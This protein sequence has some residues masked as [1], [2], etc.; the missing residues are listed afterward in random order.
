[1][2][3][4]VSPVDALVSCFPIS[5]RSIASSKMGIGDENSKLGHNAL[6]L[7]WWS[8]LYSI[9]AGQRFLD[10]VGKKFQHRLV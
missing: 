9:T 6:V 10:A 2:R 4:G 3:V 8:Q 5:K 1:M 7:P